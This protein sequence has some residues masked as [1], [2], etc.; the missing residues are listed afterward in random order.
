MDTAISD[1]LVGRIL[2]Q[3][4]LVEAKVARGGMATV[5]QALDT[6][7]DRTVALKVMH[8]AFTEDV[9]FVDRFI[10]EARAAARLS[11][12]N[13]VAVFDQGK[14]GST[15]FL[16][17]EY[18]E[19]RTLRDVLVEHGPLTP[20]QAFS[21]LGPML[22]ALAAAHE[23]GLVHRDVKPENVLL[24]DDG[25]V[26]VADFGLARM[27]SAKNSTSPQLL[28]GTVAYLSPEQVERGTADARSDVYSAGIVVFELLTGYKPF[29]GDVPIQVAY[30]H[31][32]ADVPAP[33]TLAP[34]LSPL[35]D[36]L[37]ARATARDPELRPHDAGQL[38]TEVAAVHDQLT[39]AELDA[40]PPATE[41]PAPPTELLAAAA[42]L[43]AAAAAHPLSGDLRNGAWPA[44]A[45]AAD[46]ADLQPAVA[47]PTQ[48]VAGL[49]A[50]DIELGLTGGMLGET[51]Q[52]TAV[53]PRP[54]GGVQTE[55]VEPPGAGIPPQ[56]QTADRPPERRTGLIALGI[57]LA[58]ALI[59]SV[60]AWWLGSGGDVTVPNVVGKSQA[61][62][63]RMAANAGL[64]IQYAPERVFSDTVPPD[65]IA[66]STPAAGERVRKGSEFVL[67]LSKGP[68]LFRVPKLVG[69]TREQAE[70]ELKKAHLAVG[71]ITQEF[72]A[73][74]PKGQVIATTP[75]AGSPLSRNGT[76]DL[77]ISKGSDLVDVP[78]LLGQT[79]A[80][81]IAALQAAGLTP[82][83]IQEA[84]DRDDL[85][86]RVFAQEPPGGQAP[87]G[88]TVTI[89]VGTPGGGDGDQVSVPQVTGLRVFE[90][91]RALHDAGL[92]ANVANFGGKNAQVIN[93]SP[94]PGT[95]VPAGSEV[96]IWA[97]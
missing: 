73:T 45:Q 35:L 60:G 44:A 18:V 46:G 88:S 84:T 9:D 79:Q 27:A 21:V 3:R 39:D 10:R 61:E 76:V 63:T 6:R 38:L 42:G 75:V 8:P 49:A 68:Q 2:D 59:V 92:E 56:P 30:Q 55:P 41:L 78:Y 36:A 97:L 66:K 94:A 7:L 67:Y 72:A 40:G 20:R 54:F 77:V 74:V 90:A 4:Y 13:V 23:A 91:R 51:S 53:M 85:I 65:R 33:S 19:G 12:P 28:L 25:R 93:Q 34:G 69:L 58:I 22:A 11:H 64:K 14:D 95:Q 17:M 87:R 81:A 31:V 96:T 16:A 86:G 82:Q 83:V 26:K 50:T 37:V 1:P 57:V 71:E 24:A 15:V 52:E 80:D 48:V 62:A 89:K 43:P 47:A 5:Y 70:A 32:Y 29:D